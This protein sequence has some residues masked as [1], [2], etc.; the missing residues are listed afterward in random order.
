MSLMSPLEGQPT[1]EQKQRLLAFLAALKQIS[2]ELRIVPGSEDSGDVVLYD[3]ERHTVIGIGLAPLLEGEQVSA[4]DCA[5][6]ILDG[7]WLIDT[8]D[9]PQEQRLVHPPRTP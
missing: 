8:A 2:N 1:P 9:G 7:V 4:V 5:G 3:L 6:S